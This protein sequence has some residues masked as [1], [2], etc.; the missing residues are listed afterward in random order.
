LFASLLLLGCFCVF[1]VVHGCCLLA[2]VPAADKMLVLAS[3]SLSLHLLFSLLLLVNLQLF[4]SLR[5]L[6]HLFFQILY[7]SFTASSTSSATIKS[8]K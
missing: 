4:V 3:L 2:S 1:A 6:S 5:L 8:Y 7:V